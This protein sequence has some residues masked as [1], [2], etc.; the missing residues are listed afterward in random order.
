MKSTTII[1]IEVLVR[2]RGGS[3]LFL[4][5]IFFDPYNKSIMWVL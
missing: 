5:I 1:I 2:V 3:D 4:G